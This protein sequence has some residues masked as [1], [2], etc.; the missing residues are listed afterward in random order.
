MKPRNYK[1]PVLI[2]IL[3]AFVNIVHAQIDSADAPYLKSRAIPTFT[4]I[5][6]ADSSDFSN[7]DLKKNLNTLFIIFNPDCEFCQHETIDLLKNI[8][9][10]KNTQIIM[11]TYMSHEMMKHFYTQYKIADYPEITM[12]RDDKYF[13][14]K[15]FR[16]RIMPSN[17][18]YD[19][20]GK[21]K[22]AFHQRVP[23]DT[24]LNNL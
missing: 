11:V 4:I 5:N 20:D 9:R 17:F 8:E 1:I 13:F 10:F 21:F 3:T 2:L 15:F 16:I 23:M 14:L 24:L 19:K 12:G 22:I 7:K 6:A 18:I